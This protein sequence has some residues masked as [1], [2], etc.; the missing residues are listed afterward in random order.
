MSKIVDHNEEIR[1]IEQA[2][3]PKGSEVGFSPYD[4]P[5]AIS[6]VKQPDGN[7]MGWMSKNGIVVEVRE[8]GPETVLQMLLT[9]K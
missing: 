1:K 3:K 2:F 6:I 4:N 7:W 9:H 8:V 5:N